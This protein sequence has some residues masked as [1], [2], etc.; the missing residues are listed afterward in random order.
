MPGPLSP[1]TG[2]GRPCYRL[3]MFSTARAAPRRA[4]PVAGPPLPVRA[5]IAL[6]PAAVSGAAAD[7]VRPSGEVHSTACCS[8]AGPASPTATKPRLVAVTPVTAAVAPLALRTTWVSGA[9]APAE[10]TTM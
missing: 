2:C 8:P 6:V 5:V 10:V 9:P 3:R 7:Q 4:V 1:A